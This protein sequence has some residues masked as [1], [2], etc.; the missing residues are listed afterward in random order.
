[1]GK[2]YIYVLKCPITFKVRYVGKSDDP[3]RRYKEHL[4]IKNSASKEKKQWLK[5]LKKLG[6]KPI[7]K[8]INKVP[9]DYWRDYENYY[10]SFYLRSGYN[11]VNAF[12]K[13]KKSKLIKRFRIRKGKTKKKCEICGSNF[14]V[15]SSGFVKHKCCSLH[16]LNLYNR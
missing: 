10:I 13:D 5:K 4:N 6:L 3:Y 15:P 12:T 16:C 14:L 11:L 7:L 9:D 8:I 1:V 2:T